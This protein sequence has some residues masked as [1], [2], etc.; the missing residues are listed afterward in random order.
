MHIA[1]FIAKSLQ[2]AFSRLQ[3]DLLAAGRAST[4]QGMGPSA[5]GTATSPSRGVWMMSSTSQATAWALRR[6][7]V[8]WPVMGHVWKLLWSGETSF[9]N[10]LPYSA[11]LGSNDLCWGWAVSEMQVLDGRASS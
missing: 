10:G 2:L 4:S 9:R 11:L 1:S 5:T 6:W 3:A 7:R 8:P